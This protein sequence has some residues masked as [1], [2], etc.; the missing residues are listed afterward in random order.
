MQGIEILYWA[1]SILFCLAMVFSILVWCRGW[2]KEE[3]EEAQKQLKG[4]S[5]EVD[6]LSLVVESLQHATA[7][8]Q[9]A[10]EQLNEG[11]KSLD[12]R[13]D[14]IKELTPA[15]LEA[16]ATPSSTESSKPEAAD[17]REEIDDDPYARARKLLS[18]GKSTRDVARELSIGTAEVR[19]V[20][21]VMNLP[22][23]GTARQSES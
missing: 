6:R 1:I 18:E 21:R 16:L 10:D 13:L 2:R 9:T 4:L 15:P 22:E 5:V 3:R 11:F 20:A 8:L 23:E 12:E 17:E 19:M 14:R 7:S